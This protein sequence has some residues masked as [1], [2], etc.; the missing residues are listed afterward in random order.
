MIDASLSIR[1]VESTAGGNGSGSSAGSS[2]PPIRSSSSGSPT[3]ISRGRINPP[4]LARTKASVEIYTRSTDALEVFGTKLDKIEYAFKDGKLKGILI[5]T[6]PSKAVLGQAAATIRSFRP[7]E[8]YAGKGVR[9]RGENVR[10]KA[11]KAGKK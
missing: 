10:R 2:A 8:P 6:S 5:L 7:P 9:Y 11:G 1:S 3:G 4:P